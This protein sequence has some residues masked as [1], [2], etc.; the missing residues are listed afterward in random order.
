MCVKH[1][2]KDNN[3]DSNLSLASQGLQELPNNHAFI[4]QQ[5]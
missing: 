1:K 2:K 5:D 4:P 3:H